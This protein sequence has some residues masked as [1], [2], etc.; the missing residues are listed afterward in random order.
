MHHLSR[1]RTTVCLSRRA[2]R[3][4]GYL[5]VRSSLLRDFYL[6]IEPVDGD[7]YSDHHAVEAVRLR[8][9]PLSRSRFCVGGGLAPAATTS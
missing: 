5:A 6:V 4:A 1:R 3:S 7:F 8:F 2:L 9:G